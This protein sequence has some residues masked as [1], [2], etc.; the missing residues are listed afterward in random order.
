MSVLH[1]LEEDHIDLSVLPMRFVVVDLETTGF[2]PDVDE[3]IEI[4]ALFIDREAREEQKFHALVCPT[5]PIPSRVAEVTQLSHGL[6]A[7]RGEPLQEALERFLLFIGKHRL[8]F[9][10][11]PFDMGFLEKALDFYKLQITNPVSCVLRM[12]RQ[13]W[14]GLPSY[15]LNQLAKTAGVPVD[16]THQALRDCR[17][18]LDVYKAAAFELRRDHD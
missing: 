10:N 12:A 1:S 5:K 18:V 9:F 7:C 13:A 16:G 3:I 15:K 11:A 17:L 2:S 4:G 6:L 8:V 14:P